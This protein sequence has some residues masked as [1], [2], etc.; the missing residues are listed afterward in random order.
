VAADPYAVPATID[1]TYLNRVFAAL[2][3]VDGD[4]TRIIVAAKVFGPEAAK[5]L[6]AIYAEDEFQKQVRLW[7]DLVVKGMERFKNPPGDR[8][9][10]IA[11][12]VTAKPTCIFVAVKRDYTELIGSVGAGRSNFVALR[13][14]DDSR[15]PLSFNPT[16]WAIA[17]DGYNTDGTTPANP[18]DA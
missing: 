11:Q 3:H 5:R 18:C 1:A 13:P 14:G 10:T 8:R 12:L 15:D 2:E 9:T 7:V 16:P 6:R 4:A 17:F